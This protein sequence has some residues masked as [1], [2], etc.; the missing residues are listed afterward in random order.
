VDEKIDLDALLKH[1]DMSAN[2]KLAIGDRILIPETYKRVYV[3]GDVAR[4]GFQD[5]KPGDRILDALNNAGLQPDA[6]TSK[7]NLIQVDKSKN[8][9]TMHVVRLQDFLWHGKIAGNPQVQPG[10]VL[11]IPEKRISFKPGD[12]IGAMAGVNLVNTG[13]K[14]IDYGLPAK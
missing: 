13:T 7:V 5:Y 3:F 2:R 10:D 12:L 6:D 1:G 8:T 14:I 4:P 11:Y 9:A